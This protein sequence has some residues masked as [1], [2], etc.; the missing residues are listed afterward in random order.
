MQAAGQSINQESE[1]RFATGAAENLIYTIT[2]NSDA[3]TVQVGD[4]V[5]SSTVANTLGSILGALASLINAGQT[6]VTAAANE[7]RGSVTLVAT[8]ANTAFTVDAQ[9]QQE[10]D[11]VVTDPADD[12]RPPISGDYEAPIRDVGI[13]RPQITEVLFEDVESGRS[14]AVV[15]NGHLYEARVGDNQHL[16]LSGVGAAVDVR[17]SSTTLQTIP[18]TADVTV[19]NPAGNPTADRRIDLGTIDVI[20][21]GKYTVTIAGVEFAYTAAA[22]DDVDAIAAGLA[23]EIEADAAYTASS[24]GSRV[25]VTNGAGTQSISFS[26]EGRQSDDNAGDVT[27]TRSSVA[28]QVR[29]NLSEVSVPAAGEPEYTLEIGGESFTYMASAGDT[30]ADVLEGLRVLVQARLRWSF[31][32]GRYGDRRSHSRIAHRASR[33]AHQR[34]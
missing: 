10:N 28:S 14:Y 17:F 27:I 26:F 34:G 7:V 3:Y 30:A 29:V 20:V 18:G 11:V 23:A 15:V 25:D 33:D 13:T 24:V 16:R 1:V 21:G 9:V 6:A 8:A 12:S 4:T 22:G 31:G 32:D 2:V 19:N 5:A